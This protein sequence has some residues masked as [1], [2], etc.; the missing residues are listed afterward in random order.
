MDIVVV[1]AGEVGFHLAEI[2]S[3]EGHRVAVIDANANR[4][5]HLRETLDVQAVE[6]DGTQAATLAD[7]GVG[8][9][10]LFIAVTDS[11]RVNMLTCP[12]A[13]NLGAKRVIL[14]L[15]DT[16][17]LAGYYFFYKRALGYDVALSTDELAAPEIVRLVREQHALEVE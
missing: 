3:R 1:G 9:A 16:S 5:G 12:L 4:I 15:R 10:D 14:R 13:R 8:R 6:G 2:L 17:R 11:D 7:A